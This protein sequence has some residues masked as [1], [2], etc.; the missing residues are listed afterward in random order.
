MLFNNGLS[1]EE[2][3]Q[4]FTAAADGD[5]AAGHQVCQLVI[6]R[7]NS[8][9]K[10]FAG[11]H[12][13][14]EEVCAA[15]RYGFAQALARLRN[16]QRGHDRPWLYCLAR[17][18]GEMEDHRRLQLTAAVRISRRLMRLFK[19]PAE[20][21]DRELLEAAAAMGD[22]IS[23]GQDETIVSSGASW[24]KSGDPY[25]RRALLRSLGRLSERERQVITLYYLE[26][27]TTKEIATRIVN[28]TS[29]AL[30]VTEPLVSQ[31]HKQAIAWLAQDLARQ[32]IHKEDV[33]F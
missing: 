14:Y 22:A 15:G 32:G 28:R 16:V 3:R 10:E 30:G 19:N 8:M 4:L 31:I 29:G 11:R 5:K 25:L 20:D 7:I 23:W 21:V 12:N 26:G 27:L 24:D 18:R 9:A 17:I 2:E 33:E 6:P 13:S 1:F